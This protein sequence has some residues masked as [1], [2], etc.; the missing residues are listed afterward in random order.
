[1]F[2][3]YRFHSRVVIV[4]GLASYGMGCHGKAKG[5]VAQQLGRSYIDPI[6]KF[7]RVS[8]ACLVAGI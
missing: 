7:P 6:H 3:I 1:M 8:Q 5:G 4:V 2:S